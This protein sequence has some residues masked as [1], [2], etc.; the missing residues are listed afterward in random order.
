MKFKKKKHGVEKKNNKKSNKHSRN[1]QLSAHYAAKREMVL[2][3][4]E[5]LSRNFDTPN[6]FLT[7]SGKI[8]MEFFRVILFIWFHNESWA[9]RIRSFV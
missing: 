7:T 4:M 3:F 8:F 6:P 2:H 1:T 5:T 9:L